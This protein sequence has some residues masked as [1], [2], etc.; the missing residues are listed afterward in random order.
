M[1]LAPGSTFAGYT[2]VR[3][4]GTGASG[5][6]YLA[7]H[8]ALPRQDALKVLPRSMTAD[9]KFRERFQRETEIAATLYHPH[10]VEVYGRGEFEGQLWIAMEYLDGVNA[11]QLMREHFPAGMPAGEALS[12][13]AAI[14]WALD[15]AHQ[16]GILH[17][18][19]KPADIF[20]TNPGGGE[21]R[22]LLAD[23]GLAREI[24]T[25]RRLARRS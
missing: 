24:G 18:A 25:A 13:I 6:V 7:Q 10:I 11:A 14:A 3:M 1:P 12:I 20:L 8:P 15:Y 19:V 9:R 21:P 22:I 2:I 4:L 16:R 23:F 5:E 17:R